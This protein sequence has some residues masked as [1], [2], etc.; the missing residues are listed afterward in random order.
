MGSGAL[1]SIS[2]SAPG[3]LCVELVCVCVCVCVC[4]ALVAPLFNKCGPVTQFGADAELRVNLPV[5]VPARGLLVVVRCGRRI[6]IDHICPRG[7]AEEIRHASWWRCSL[8]VI[9]SQN[10]KA[11]M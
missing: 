10:A 7:G 9:S 6:I 3:S 2:R 11:I 1:Y 8:V 5:F 4:V